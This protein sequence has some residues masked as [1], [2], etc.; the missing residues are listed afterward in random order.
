MLELLCMK[1]FADLRTRFHAERA[2]RGEAVLQAWTS[3]LT[4]SRSSLRSSLSR[5]IRY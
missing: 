1:Q 4:G 2:T 5:D 3:R